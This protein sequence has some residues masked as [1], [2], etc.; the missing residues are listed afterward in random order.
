M[1][2]AA[3][4]TSFMSA[5]PK[6][7]NFGAPASAWLTALASVIVAAA[8]VIAT[9]L[10]R[11]INV[12]PSTSRLLAIG[13]GTILLVVALF[14]A[15]LLIPWISPRV[16]LAS[17]IALALC[18]AVAGIMHLLL[19][20]EHLEE[21][22]LL[23]LGFV[24]A[25][26]VQIVLAAI[27]IWAVLRRRPARAGYLAI[28]ALNAALVFFYA[29]HVWLGLPLA[30]A[31]K[32]VILGMQEQIDV[33]GSLTKVVELVSFLLAFIWLSSFRAGGVSGRLVQSRQVE[34]EVP[35]PD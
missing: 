6:L 9:A 18:L 7:Q 35:A 12:G 32:G 26:L 22:T 27:V 2:H 33:P 24:A 11:G 20:R 19:T 15:V 23:G 16:R 28:I 14:L 4:N 21:S 10:F 1:D 5:E 3:R 30:G 29:V 17:Q 8:F 13:G 31:P 25:G 34:P